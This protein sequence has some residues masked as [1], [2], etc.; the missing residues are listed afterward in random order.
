LRR[1]AVQIVL[2]APARLETATL[3]LCS[4]V[5]KQRGPMIEAWAS[6]CSLP[7]EEAVTPPKM[8]HHLP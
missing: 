7:V 8:Q 6:L 1:L 4:F 5:L 2:S 3:T